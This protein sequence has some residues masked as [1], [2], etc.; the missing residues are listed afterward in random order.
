MLEHD[1]EHY[2]CDPHGL[3]PP[4]RPPSYAAATAMAAASTAA[5]D[6]VS[7]APPGPGSPLALCRFSPIARAVVDD[8]AKRE[9][10]SLT[11]DASSHNGV[12][13]GADGG[14]ARAA[15]GGAAVAVPP[16][17]TV[18]AVTAPAARLGTDS[19][20][21]E[22]VPE[23]A[24]AQEAVRSMVV[25]VPEDAFEGQRLVVTSPD[26]SPQEV[27]VPDGAVAGG[28]FIMNYYAPLL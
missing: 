3:S 7:R 28:M 14:A 24:A 19:L 25:R 2:D 13:N 20:T 12:H 6:A 22:A 17:A 23:A 26:G 15:G 1:R 9:H 18:A 27:L 10:V 5:A 11:A 16:A 21:Q 4:W 8:D